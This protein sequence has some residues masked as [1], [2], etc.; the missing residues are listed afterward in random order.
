[1]LLHLQHP[2]D[3]DVVQV[4]MQRDDGVD[5]GHVQRQ[6][7]RDVTGIERSLQQ[8]FQPAARYDHR[9][10]PANCVRNR[11]SFSNSTRISGMPWRGMAMGSGPM[12]PAK[13]VERSL[14]TLPFFWTR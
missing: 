11:T 14:A 5:G 10:P 2:G 4:L 7:L 8:R 1:M 3:Q 13:P 12:P 6:A 9:V